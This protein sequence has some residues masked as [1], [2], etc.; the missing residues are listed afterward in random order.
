MK[1]LRRRDDG[2]ALVEMVVVVSVL[3]LL[4]LG[5]VEMGF[6]FRD[7]LGIEAGTRA[8]ARIA[9]QAGKQADNDCIILESV[10]GAVRSLH[11]ELHTVHVYKSNTSGGYGAAQ[12][13]TPLFTDE[14]GAVPLTC[15]S[16]GTWYRL[17]N[18]W[19]A[20]ARVNTGNNRDWIGVRLDFRHDWF[21]GFGMFSGGAEWST[22]VVMRIEPDPTAGK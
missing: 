13:Y 20:S 9:A 5:S 3:I 21:T 4:V 12:R 2:A 10:A 14:T 6:A 7:W 19:P 8:G 11:G 1:R 16:T 18:S 15:T 22:D 17:Q